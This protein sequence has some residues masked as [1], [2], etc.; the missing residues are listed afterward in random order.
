MMSCYITFP[1]RIFSFNMLHYI[2]F[3]F[4]NQFGKHFIIILSIYYTIYIHTICISY[5]YFNVYT[6]VNKRYITIIQPTTIYYIQMNLKSFNQPNN[7]YHLFN[8]CYKH[9]CIILF[10]YKIIQIYASYNSQC[11]MYVI[12]Q[13]I[14]TIQHTDRDETNQCTLTMNIEI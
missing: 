14:D 9:L 3:N 4:N 8:C 13:S 10:H 6:I 7:R 5:V 1:L 12:E 2:T 11:M